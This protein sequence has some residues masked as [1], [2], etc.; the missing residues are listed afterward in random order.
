MVCSVL[1][2]SDSKEVGEEEVAV[3]AVVVGDEDVI[4][5]DEEAVCD[6]LVILLLVVAVD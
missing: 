3:D 6:K 1:V 5:S 4:V 2:E